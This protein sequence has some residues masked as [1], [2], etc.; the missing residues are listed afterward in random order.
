MMM[1]NMYLTLLMSC[2]R[3]KLWN[4]EGIKNIRVTPKSQFSS[5]SG[6]MSQE[7]KTL[8]IYQIQTQLT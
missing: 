5:K 3:Q 7:R 2:W 4:P 1:S 8:D 6:I